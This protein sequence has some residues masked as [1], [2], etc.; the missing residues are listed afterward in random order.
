MP[1]PPLP[2]EFGQGMGQRVRTQAQGAGKT[3]VHP[4]QSG[5]QA[6]GS[7]GA[8]FLGPPWPNR[9]MLQTHR[10]KTKLCVN[11][12]PNHK[13]QIRHALMSN[14]NGK[15]VDWK[16]RIASRKT[17]KTNKYPF[18][19]HT[20]WVM[21]VQIYFANEGRW[22]QMFRRANFFHSAANVLTVTF[23]AVCCACFAF[24]ESSLVQQK[25]RP[26]FS[27]NFAKN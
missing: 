11:Q 4:H 8:E 23:M 15:Q 19:I 17:N 14:I 24:G 18:N 9:E 26:W 1:P 10:T 20:D 2:Q 12:V 7:I 16:L 6:T 27:V 21:M 22:F 25:M 3:G 13:L 5:R